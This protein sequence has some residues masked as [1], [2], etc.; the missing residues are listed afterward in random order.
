MDTAYERAKRELENLRW[1]DEAIDSRAEHCKRLREKIYTLSASGT[2]E[3]VSGTKSADIADGVAKLTDYERELN[4]EIDEYIARRKE[5]VAKIRSLQNGMAAS[6]LYY[7][8]VLG[9]TDLETAE[10]ISYSDRHIRRLRHEG[11]AEYADKFCK[12]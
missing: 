11:L 6:V 2:S 3:P 9:M 7:F 5:I 10:K 4:A 8:Y 1:I 12:I